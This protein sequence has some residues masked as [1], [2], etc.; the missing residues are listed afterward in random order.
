MY[1][2]RSS[3]L[4]FSSHFLISSGELRSAESAVEVVL[5]DLEITSSVTKIG[6]SV[7]NASAMASEGRESTVI[8]CPPAFRNISFCLRV[9]FFSCS[10]FTIQNN[11]TTLRTK[12]IV[13]LEGIA[14]VGANILLDFDAGQGVAAAAAKGVADGK[15]FTTVGTD[16]LAGFS[17]KLNVFE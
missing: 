5:E 4:R 14:A 9:F 12:S 17:V 13:W 8:I 10:Q 2:P 11:N 7:R 6:E 16:G 15:G 1:F 3:G